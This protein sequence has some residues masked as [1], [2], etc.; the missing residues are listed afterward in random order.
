MTVTTSDLRALLIALTLG[1]FLAV[2][3]AK[4]EAP[5]KLENLLKSSLESSSD[6]E[7]IVSLVE[8][9]PNLTLPKHYHPG[10]EF[11]YALEG[12]ATLWLKDQPDV[13]LEAGQVAK[14]PLEQVHTAIT[15]D[16][17][18]KAIVFRVHKKGQPERI[19]H[20]V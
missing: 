19:H 7:V 3:P 6:L 13:V 11:I 10:E 8:I 2:S 15:G 14:V 4:A 16:Q 18:V 5:V 9:G 17:P 1:L 12:S 20:R